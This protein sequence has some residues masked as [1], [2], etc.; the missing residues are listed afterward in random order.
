[1]TILSTASGSALMT[2]TGPAH[3]LWTGISTAWRH[4]TTICSAKLS[5]AVCGW[6]P[7]P[8]SVP[9]II[10]H[11]IAQMGSERSAP[12]NIANASAACP[13]AIGSDIDQ[14]C[15]GDA[16]PQ[17]MR[18]QANCDVRHEYFIGFIQAGNL[19]PKCSRYH[20]E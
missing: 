15:H 5:P 17:L 14:R 18:P 10:Y 16:V 8:R 11:G 3:R 7:R 20:D 1:M 9:Q 13:Q 19:V 4:C 12:E 2:G 6:F